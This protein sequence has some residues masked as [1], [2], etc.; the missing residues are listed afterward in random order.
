MEK[1]LNNKITIVVVGRSGSG[2]GTQ[3]KYLLERFGNTVY[4]VETGK[5]I[6]GLMGRPNPTAKIISD[7]I[8]HGNLVPS[9]LAS[10][11]WVNEFLEHDIAD[12]N[13]VFDGSPR[14]V[15]EA[16]IMDEVM[17]FH[18]R[19]LPVCLNVE[20]SE[21]I[22]TERLLKRGRA[23]DLPEVI[24]NRLKYFPEF[25]VPVIR[26][27]EERGRLVTVDGNM[28]PE[29]VNKNTHLALGKYLGDIWQQR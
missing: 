23:D 3:A 25:V 19:S 5:I 1:N 16:K 21:E 11:L 15:A 27:Y 2:K 18:K 20:V 28:S 22:V 10:Y 9:W 26:Y 8:A 6:R 7:V 12:K 24:K 4:Y 13:L 17:E 29:E 14:T